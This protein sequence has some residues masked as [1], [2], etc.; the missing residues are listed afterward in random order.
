M[1]DEALQQ[2]SMRFGEVQQQVFESWV[3]PALFELGMGNFLEDAYTGTG[4][5]MVGVLQI[6]I[7]LLGIGLL[8]RFW[9]AEVQ[10]GWRAVWP[11][12]FYTCL[13]LSLIHI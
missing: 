10:R 6:V 2:F 3:Q 9:P 5:F 1:L 13:H 4:W 12:V 11:D 7:M 8:E